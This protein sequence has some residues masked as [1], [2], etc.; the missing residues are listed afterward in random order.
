MSSGKGPSL[1][2]LGCIGSALL[3]VAS[4]HSVK[5]IL[6]FDWTNVNV[7]YALEHKLSQFVAYVFVVKL[8]QGHLPGLVILR[9]I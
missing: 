1:H 9:I 4:E 3:L 2:I 6:Y 7:Q 8:F 5:L